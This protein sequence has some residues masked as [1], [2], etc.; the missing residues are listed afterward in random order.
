MESAHAFTSIPILDLSLATSPDTRPKLLRQLHH[1][2]V[3]V[4]FLYVTNHGVPENT[5][6]DLISILPQFFGLPHVDKQEIALCNS[7]HFLGY[8]QVGAE[9]TAGK[10]DRR[11]QVEFATELEAKYIEGVGM[12]LYERL[13]GPN[14]VGDHLVLGFS[15]LQR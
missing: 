12:P 5:I 13:I 7:P 4:G 15:A 9:M 6:N 11:E 2:L 8:S 14:Q 1:A 10:K 3:S